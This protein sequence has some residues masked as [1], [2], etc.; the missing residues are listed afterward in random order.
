MLKDGIATRPGVVDKIG[1]G[2]ATPADG[3]VMP[4]DCLGLAVGST[5]APLPGTAV[6]AA[7]QKVTALLAP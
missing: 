1:D 7:V 4:V 5:V 2:Q 3:E 6:V